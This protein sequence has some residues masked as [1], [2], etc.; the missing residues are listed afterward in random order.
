ML[1]FPFF[2]VFLPCRNYFEVD[3]LS[4]SLTLTLTLLVASRHRNIS[5]PISH[6]LA[7]KG[8]LLRTALSDL[9]CSPAQFP[10]RD[11]MLP[12]STSGWRMDDS[13]NELKK[14]NVIFGV[15]IKFLV[16]FLDSKFRVH[17]NIEE[18]LC[19]SKRSSKNLDIS[20]I[21]AGRWGLGRLSHVPKPHLGPF[22]PQL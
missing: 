15:E 2:M 22:D 4:L 7:S 21:V 3:F 14:V 19:Y 10:I 12:A 11:T 8:S 20:H 13:P 9:T 17:S 5:C 16:Y 6:S 18:T 1:F